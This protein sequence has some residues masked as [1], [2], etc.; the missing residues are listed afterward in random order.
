MVKHIHIVLDDE[1]YELLLERKEKS[2]WKDLLMKK[3]KG[4]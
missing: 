1:E 3:S 4:G 2:T